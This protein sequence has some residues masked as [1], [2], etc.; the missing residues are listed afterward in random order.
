MRRNSNT[1]VSALSAYTIASNCSD[2]ADIDAGLSEIQSY[3]EA[4]ARE[5]VK[6]AKTAYVRLHKLAVIKS[7]LITTH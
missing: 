2:T 4:C 1:K 5:G 3:F 6:P 7:I